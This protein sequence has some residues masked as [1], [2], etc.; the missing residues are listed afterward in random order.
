MHYEFINKSSK[1]D[2]IQLQRKL[3]ANNSLELM[4]KI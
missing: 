4:N 1:G 3:F 2:D